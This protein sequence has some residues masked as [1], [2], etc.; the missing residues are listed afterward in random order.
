MERMDFVN[1]RNS[2]LTKINLM[3]LYLCHGKAISGGLQEAGWG[4]MYVWQCLFLIHI[5]FNVKKKP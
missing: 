2:N 5:R 1:D 4:G 3:L